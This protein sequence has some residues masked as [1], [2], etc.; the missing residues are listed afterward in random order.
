MDRRTPTPCPPGASIWNKHKTKQ[1]PHRG[2]H[3]VPLKPVPQAPPLPLPQRGLGLAGSSRASPGQAS[4]PGLPQQSLLSPHP[5]SGAD[6]P[7]ASSP[8]DTL[9]ATGQRAEGP[10]FPEDTATC[11]GPRA[12]PR[13]CLKEMWVLP[14]STQ[15]GMWRH[16]ADANNAVSSG[17]VVPH[18]GWSRAQC[19][20]RPGPGESGALQRPSGR[21][22]VRT[23]PKRAAGRGGRAEGAGFR[24]TIRKHR[25]EFQLLQSC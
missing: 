2:D 9:R 11:M 18:V 8:P 19:L 22:E 1:A 12:A 16:D 3:W 17:E 15:W 24:F 23:P 6:G 7:L 20:P 21:R 25:F 5:P 4:A 14:P 13:S 10:S